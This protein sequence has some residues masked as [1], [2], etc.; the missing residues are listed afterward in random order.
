MM[1]LQGV[2]HNVITDGALV[3]AYE[4]GSQLWQALEIIVTM[5]LQGVVPTV[6]AYNALMSACEK[7]CQL[8]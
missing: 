6:V 5:N 1:A 8:G 7:G 3:H 2:V 4:Q